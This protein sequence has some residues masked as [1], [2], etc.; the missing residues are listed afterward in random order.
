MYDACWPILAELSAVAGRFDL[1]IAGTAGAV[2]NPQRALRAPGWQALAR[3]GAQPFVGLRVGVSA[4]HGPYIGVAY[5]STL[6][7]S[8][9]P[10]RP[11]DFDQTLFGYDVE[12]ARGRVQ[13]FS[14]GYWN[15]WNTAGVPSGLVVVSGYVEARLDVSAQWYVGGRLG[16]MDFSTIDVGGAQESWDDDLW[17]SELAVGYR[18]ARESLV[19]LGWQRWHYTSG[20]DPDQD[21]L[22]VQLSTV[23]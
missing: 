20:I 16:G 7:V 2:S 12:Y 21:V 22:A 6:V 23:F 18:L 9:A 11:Q 19:R 15:R 1:T 3:V 8:P 5:D 13:L 14:E 4:A 10:Q 17:R